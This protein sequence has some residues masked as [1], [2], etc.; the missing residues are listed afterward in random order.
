ML[1]RSFQLF[2]GLLFS[3]GVNISGPPVA[4]QEKVIDAALA[5]RYFQE[6]EAICKSDNGR[7]WGVS[8]CGP[9]LFVDPDTRVVVANQSDREG[10]LTKKGGLFLGRLPE[11][12]AAANTSINWAGVKWTMILWPLPAN[13]YARAGLM[14]HELFHRIQS[15]IGLP[16]VNPSN[17]HLDSLEGRI[18]LQLEWRALREAVTHH[19]VE[20]RQAAADALVF[21]ALRHEL[22][23]QAASQ[24]RALEMNEGLAEYTGV[25]LSGRTEAEMA[26]YL[27]GQLDQASNKPTFVRSFAYASGPAYGFLLD[28]AEVR[29][30]QHLK[31]QE[32][33]GSFLQ[34]A[35]SVTLPESLK[36]EAERRSG[37]YDGDLLRA[38]ETEREWGRLARLTEYR[39]RLVDGPVL[40][41]P[42]TKEVQ[43]S[44]NP[45]NL[46]PVGEIGTV[47]PT[48]RVSD[49]W[50]ILTVTGGAMMTPNRDAVRVPVSADLKKRPPQGEGWT[51]QLNEGWRLEAGE[52]KGDY[53]L[54]KSSSP[55]GGR[56]Q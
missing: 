12:V 49:A 40:I 50:G 56:N 26:G 16:A 15:D 25:H 44:F 8:L 31:S 39:A 19:G 23:S 35:M 18:W 21:R 29:W 22:F 46:Q 33:L 13:K 17:N 24:E 51:L 38:A 11:E 6:A 9:M 54:K 53:V 36:V 27:A 42:L 28:Q 34:R 10:R 4:A 1:A 55:T 30:R 48:L 5:G 43:Y 47:Y 20:R 32:D 2:C 14:L 45:N 7:L 41:L 52:R 37:S 3:F